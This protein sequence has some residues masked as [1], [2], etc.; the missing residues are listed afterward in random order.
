MTRTTATRRL[1]N[2]EI[3]DKTPK[4]LAVPPKCSSCQV[5]RLSLS[6]LLKAAFAFF[7]AR[8]CLAAQGS[9]W[10]SSWGHVPQREGGR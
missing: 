5:S 1:L 6:A 2:C 7:S 3:K 8:Q 10:G 4:P 9:A